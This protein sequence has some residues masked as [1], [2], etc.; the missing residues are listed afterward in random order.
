MIINHN[1]SSLFASRQVGLTQGSITKDMEKLSSGMKIN[2]ASDDAAGLALSE[3]MRTQIRGLNMASKNVSDMTSFV[4]TADGYMQETTDVLQRI[5]ELAVQSSNGIYSDEDRLQIQVEVS[6]L[7]SEIDRI[8]SSAQF[9]GMNI[10]TGRFAENGNVFHIGVNTDQTISVKIGNVSSEALGLT[11]Q[12]NR[13]SVADQES[14][15]LTIAT[16]DEALKAV[17]KNRA[18]VGATMNRAEMAKKGIDIAAENLQAADS[19]IRDTDMAQAMTEYTRDAIL[20][21]AG[22]AMLAQANNSSQNVLALL[23]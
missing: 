7:V 19:R 22:T 5:R 15:N 11:A 13:I 16:I 21:Q 14:A 3:K 20:Q 1:M 6:S 8:A 4:Q 23:K 2:R 12:G 18:D 10:L 9:N 17:L